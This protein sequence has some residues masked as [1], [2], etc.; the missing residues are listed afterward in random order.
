MR[1][2]PLAACSA[3]VL[4]VSPAH[5]GYREVWNPPESRPP[6]IARPHSPANRSL[7]HRAHRSHSSQSAGHANRTD[8][9]VRPVA[10]S[11]GTSLRKD[12]SDLTPDI[13]VARAKELP[14]VIAPDGSILRT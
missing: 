8:R 11:P 6:V 14:P 1:I 10:Q 7:T 3:L 5:A 9:P 4:A 12:A 13:P 2:I